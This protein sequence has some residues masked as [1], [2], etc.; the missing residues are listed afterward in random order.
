ML[1]YELWQIQLVGSYF[2][3]RL[4]APKLKPPHEVVAAADPLH[5]G[6]GVSIGVSVG[7][8]VG[9]AP[10]FGDNGRNGVEAGAAVPAGVLVHMEAACTS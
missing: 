8:G 6:A 7:L 3:K 4:G 9:E 1:H 5:N 2:F 10:Q